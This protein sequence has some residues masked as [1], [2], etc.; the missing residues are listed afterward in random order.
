MAK[1]VD[2]VFDVFMKEAVNLDSEQTKKAKC[3]RDWLI[4]Q[5]HQFNY[6]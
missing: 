2:Q 6:I 3:S 5:I 1:T 4:G